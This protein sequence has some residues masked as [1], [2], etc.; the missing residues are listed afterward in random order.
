MQIDRWN[1]RTTAQPVTMMCAEH[2]G[3]SMEHGGHCSSQQ[4]TEHSD[5]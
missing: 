3:V 2:Q 4:N 5:S 1:N